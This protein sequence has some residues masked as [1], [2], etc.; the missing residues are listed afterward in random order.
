M[1]LFLQISQYVGFFSTEV[2]NT[3]L[4]W[5]IITKSSRSFGSYKYIMMSYAVFSI[6]YAVVE[7][8]TRPVMHL[9]GA[10]MFIYVD[11]F[12]KF[13]KPIAL[14]LVGLY[15]ATFGM[16]VNLLA[17][18]FVY[19]FFAICR[20]QDMHHFQGVNLLKVYLIPVVSSIGW[21]YNVTVLM[22][23]S[24]VKSEYMRE[25]INETYGEDTFKVGY[26]AALYYQS[27]FLTMI[28]CGWK[29]YRKMESVGGTMS[30]KTKELN[31]QL[32]R[33]LVIQTLIPLCIMFAPVGS[34]IILPMFSIGVGKLANAP[35]FYAGFYPALDALIAIFMI[36]DFRRTV[37]CKKP[38]K[39]SLSSVAP[40]GNYSSY[41]SG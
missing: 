8:M 14:F 34:L 16:C 2:T 36:R 4:L 19:R 20:P 17:T 29:T 1:P 23:P 32:F 26:I 13:E 39:K 31:N 33:A 9:H 3:V 6:V 24:D 35:G 7:I 12:L 25:S 40:D 41:Q 27:C 28:I 37:L 38:R 5:L 22:G 30:K 10:C 21:Y 11:S 15:C 18:H